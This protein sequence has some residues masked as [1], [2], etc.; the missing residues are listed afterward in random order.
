[1]L[2]NDRAGQPLTAELVSGPAHG[3]LTLNADGSFRYVPARDFHGIDTFSYRACHGDRA[4]AAAVVTITVTPV[5]D[6]RIDVKPGSRRNRINLRGKG[7]LP[8]AILSTQVAI[9][10]ETLDARA[11]DPASLRFGD[12]RL[13]GRVAPIRHKLIDLDRDGHLDLLVHFSLSA[14]RQTGALRADSTEAMLTGFLR[15]AGGDLAP[16][17]GRDSVETW[18]PPLGLL[19][20]VAIS[21]S[22]VRRLP[23]KNW[24][25]AG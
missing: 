4:S 3:S 16:F 23:V 8:V 5:L 17:E 20:V 1:M 9:G 6:A 22:V 15:T 13:T 14:L 11:I 21:M 19:A 25:K 24:P 18:M 10:G 7:V 12:P 2:G